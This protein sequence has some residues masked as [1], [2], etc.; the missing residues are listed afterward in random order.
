MLPDKV[1]I[2]K[3]A[4][5]SGISKGAVRAYIKRGDWREGHEWFRSPKNRIMISVAGADAW[6]VSNYGNH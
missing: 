1:T 3:Y 2:E 4:E 5:L 6:V